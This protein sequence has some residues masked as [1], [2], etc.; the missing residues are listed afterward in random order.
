M[1][2]LGQGSDLSY[3]CSQYLSCSHGNARSLTHYAELWMEPVNQ[4]FQ[5]VVNP[6]AP[7]RELLYGLYMT[8]NRLIKSTRKTVCVLTFHK[9]SKFPQKQESVYSLLSIAFMWVWFW[10]SLFLIWLVK[11]ACYLVSSLT[12]I[13]FTAA[14]VLSKWEASTP[15]SADVSNPSQEWPQEENK[16]QKRRNV[17]EFLEHI[18]QSIQNWDTH[19]TQAKAGTPGKLIVKEQGFP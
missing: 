12:F 7:Q 4:C 16:Y 11:E 6:I 10:L 8:Y 13:L 2:F 19:S 14:R 3:S 1:E 17:E 5:D 18:R 15:K 9:P